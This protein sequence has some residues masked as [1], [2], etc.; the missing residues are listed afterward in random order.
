M[1]SDSFVTFHFSTTPEIN[2]I[3]LLNLRNS[4]IKSDSKQQINIIS[5]PKCGRTWLRLMIGRAISKHYHCGS[6]QEVLILGELSKYHDE[7]PDMQVRHDDDAFFKSVDE[8]TQTKK[9]YQDNKVLFIVRDPRDVIIS[10][11]FHKTKRHNFFPN[12]TSKNEY[13]RYDG[14][15]KEFIREKVGSF[16]TLLEY[17]NIWDR[18]RDQP[19][20]FLMVSYEQMSEN[21]HQTLRSTLDFMG[22]DKINEVVIEESIEYASFDNMRDMERKD[23]FESGILK[24]TNNNDLN[25]FK[26]RKGKVGGYVE[27][28][29]DE[30]IEYLNNCIHAKLS[31]N[32]V[33]YHY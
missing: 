28:L 1:K 24:S 29:D 14:T 6:L 2:F 27:F 26:T 8:L 33:D 12:D 31:K 23:S 15:L 17:Y 7:I 13:A 32:Y 20:G 21:T 19:D 4:M 3:S 30:D 11:F 18:S 25:S 5:Y 22:L 9:E 16:E 10:S